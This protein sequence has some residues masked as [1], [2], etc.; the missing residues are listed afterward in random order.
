MNQSFLS[1]E[2]PCNLPLF[3]L[4]FPISKI[5]PKVS[6]APKKMLTFLGS[7]CVPLIIDRRFWSESLIVRDYFWEQVEKNK[8]GANIPFELTS[9]SLGETV[10]CDH[11]IP[12]IDHKEGE[13]IWIHLKSV[14]RMRVE[15]GEVCWSDID[16]EAKSRQT[17]PS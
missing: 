9:S 7:S 8:T 15:R 3:S 6:K 11:Q 1:F 2:L 16:F 10:P 13:G 12:F 4:L 14:V 17:Q 5:A